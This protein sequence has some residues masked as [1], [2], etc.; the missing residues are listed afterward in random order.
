[1]GKFTYFQWYQEAYLK[2]SNADAQDQF[3]KSA[4]ISGDTI[5]VGAPSESS[6][7]T[8]ITNGST[9]SGDNTVQS[10]GA[11]YVFKRTGSNWAQEAYL[12][13]PNAEPYDNFGYYG[14]SISGDTIVV[15]APYESSNQTTITNGPTASGD[16]TALG[17]GAAYVFKR[18]GSNWAQEA[19]L[20]APN[21]HQYDAFGYTAS[22]SGD[23]IVVGAPGESSN[24]TTITNGPTASSNISAPGSGAAYVF[25]RTGSNWT[26]E[27]YIKASNSDQ[28]DEFGVTT[29]VSGD[30]IV[31]GAP[32]ESSN[33]TTITNGS[34]ASSDNTLTHSG[35]AYVFKRTG[36]NW[37]QEAYLKAPNAD[38]SD[39]FGVV[40]SISGDTIVVGAFGESSNQTTITNGSTASSDN[41]L[42]DSGAAYVF[43]RTGSNWAQEAYLK[44]PNVHAHDWFGGAS[45]SGDTIVVGASNESS[46]QTTITNGSTASSDTSAPSSGAAYVFKR[47]GSNWAQE[48][49]L[50][51]P[52]A[53]AG[54]GYEGSL[55]ISGDT[56]VLGAPR[57]SSNQT[58]I[59]NGSTAS[60][61]NSLTNSGAA[62]VVRR[63]EVPST[64][65]VSSVTPASGAPAGDNVI[66]FGSGF[67][68]SAS[69]TVGG[70]SCATVTIQ[71][72]NE[73]I[74]NLP[75]KPASGALDIVV[76]NPNSNGSS[77][78]S[79]AYTYP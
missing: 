15:G 29:S 49:Y 42:I 61:D 39:W 30:T 46:N 63:H 71:G 79:S 47:T 4:S 66:I 20:K 8:T 23:T 17:S 2:A 12:K 13:A 35:A 21:A 19:Y 65:T 9:A 70:A 5:V 51:A 68:K 18:T 43:K 58:T 38:M 74:C 25:K 45:I 78:L 54:D 6:N 14:T 22:I 41:S 57:E 77:T 37:A 1:M 52:N 11:A 36:S 7:Q 24:Q 34:T 26:Q 16:N 33:Q 32:Y 75:T 64:P 60:S 3:G 76:T 10:S 44:A 73:I 28:D 55:S 31:V 40:P 48:A 72:P 50:K 27:A 69:V 62:Y 53:D 59:T 67:M 56:I